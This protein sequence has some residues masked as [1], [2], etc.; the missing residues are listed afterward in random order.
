[1]HMECVLDT[2][3]RYDR[4]LRATLEPTASRSRAVPSSSVPTG[5]AYLHQLCPPCHL[6]LLPCPAALRPHRHGLRPAHFPHALPTGTTRTPVCGCASRRCR[7]PRTASAWRSLTARAAASSSRRG[8]T[9][10]ARA[11]SPTLRRSSIHGPTPGG[12]SPR[13]QRLGAL[14]TACYPPAHVCM[15]SH[16]HVHSRRATCTRRANRACMHSRPQVWAHAAR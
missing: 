12:C 4:R 11:A 2:F 16:V 7:T 13:Y 9:S 10:P 6:A 14:R 1:M 8:G 15:H 5:L 3:D